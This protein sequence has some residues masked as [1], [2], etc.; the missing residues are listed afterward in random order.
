MIYNKKTSDSEKYPL[1]YAFVKLSTRKDA[2]DVYRAITSND[3]LAVI[4]VNDESHKIRLGWVL[5][6]IILLQLNSNSNSK[7]RTNTT[8]HISHLVLINIILLQ[9]NSNSNSNSRIVLSLKI[10]YMV[11]FI[12]MVN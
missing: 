6:N 10:R 2:Q 11:C 5:I 1:N 7:A 4:V 9:L 12:N 3:S 8:L